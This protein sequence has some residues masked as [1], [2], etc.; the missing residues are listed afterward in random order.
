MSRKTGVLLI[1]LGTPAAPTARAVGRYLTQFLSD[2]RVVDLA[3]AVW[4]PLLRGVIV[5]VRSRRVARQYRAVWQEGGSPLLVWSRQQQ[6]LLQQRLPDAVIALGMCY[7]APSIAEA[8][9]AVLRQQ[10]DTLIVL[11]LYPQ[12]SCSTTAAAWDS[13]AAALRAHRRLPALRFIRDYADHPAYIAA[14]RQQVLHSRAQHGQPD[15]LICS[16]HGIPQRYAREG[17]DYPQ[18]CE[19]TFRALQ[20]ALQLDDQQMIMTYQSRFGREPWLTPYM[21]EVIRQ[22]PAQGVKSVQ[23]ICPGFAADCLETLE[24]IDHTYRQAFLAA[25]GEQFHYIPAL[26]AQPAHITLLETL[27]REAETPDGTMRG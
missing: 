9:A 15:R 17:D 2:R 23:V 22:L 27:I 6:Q 10:P 4:Q 24:E 7:G 16:F 11:A 1:N 13:V 12:Y 19:A 21:D 3:P 14:L 25:G 26:N 20:R 18:R 8:L 5:P